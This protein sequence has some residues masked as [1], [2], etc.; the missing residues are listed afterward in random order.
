[1]P[2]TSVRDW[3]LSFT[4]AVLLVVV[5][6]L[7]QY[8]TAVSDQSWWGAGAG[9]GMYT[10]VDYHGSRMLRVTLHTD[11]GAHRVA[12][13]SDS[14]WRARVLPTQSNIDALAD[15]LLDATWSVAANIRPDEPR[16]TRAE[17]DDGGRVEVH[18]VD[19]ELLRWNFDSET[20]TVTTWRS[21]QATAP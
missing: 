5:A 10:T 15:E 3:A 21:H 16:Y 12:V 19:V 20:A 18:R 1:M 17:P 7:H 8:R 9:F 11:E 6:T 4:P 13:N 14:A 2:A